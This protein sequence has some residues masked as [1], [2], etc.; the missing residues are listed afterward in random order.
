[1]KKERWQLAVYDTLIFAFCEFLLFLAVHHVGTKRPVGYFP[2]NILISFLLIM[3]CRA[4]F[5]IYRLIW[6]YG[7]VMS[8]A[9]III[10][11]GI[12]FIISS[13]RLVSPTYGSMDLLCSAAVFSLDL[14]LALS[15]RMAYLYAFQHAGPDTKRSRFFYKLL[16]IFSG[17][18]VGQKPENSSAKKANIAILGAG[19]LG[20]GLA[21]SLL[22]SPDNIFVPVCFIDSNEGKAGRNINGLPV[23]YESE[24]TTEKLKQ[25]NVD[26]IVFAIANIDDPLRIKL[27]NR[28]HSA[29]FHIKIYDHHEF[30]SANGK[31]RLRE[32]E[33]E[34]LLFRKP[35]DIVGGKAE[36]YYNGKTVLI[37]GAG[38]SIGSELA[39]QIAKFL[40][41]MLVL[42]DI[43]ENGVYDVE[44]ELKREYGGAVDVHPE[45]LS[46]CNKEGLCRLFEK[47]KP[48][49]II[50]AAAHKHVPLMENNSIEAIENNVFGTKT[51]V[52]V[53]EKYEAER[54]MMV[55]TDKAVNPT[56]VMGAT[57]RMCEMIVQS[58]SGYGKVKYSATRFGNVLG[59][60]G[61]VI[62]LFK[63]QIAAGGPITIT[64]KR[65]I[66]Y[67]MTIPEASQLVLE[68]GAM[69]Q[70]GEL[71]VLD[72]GQPVKIIDLAENIIKLSGVR[73]I[74]IVETGLRP[75]EKLY[76][77]LLMK[78]EKL[79]K[80]ENNKIFIEYDQRM[81]KSAIDEKLAV[82][83]E[84]CDSNSND[85]AKEA[86]K[87]VV[88]TYQSPEKVNAQALNV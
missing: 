33:I 24:S 25:M 84:A 63:R 53:C 42:L 36:K 21:E 18:R 16:R 73:N 62:P 59:S 69:A 67:F 48:Q 57:K 13:I 85:L 52:D 12:A 23:L 58:A 50:H 41:K 74:K 49:I 66:R 71:F 75:G 19:R 68:S 54:F 15:M 78:T 80:T 81:D 70:N 17:G 31:Y 51:L 1:M 39:R 32:F 43:C 46:V 6:R 8:Y 22:N 29:G 3:I 44:Q 9:K 11:D 61:S 20:A 34:D 65:I 86:L 47:Y 2:V 82:L 87:R 88:P 5:G 14:I 10:S 56:N 37:T 45:I 7:G 26:T 77:E 72:M 60:A 35:I 27:Y 64:D 28:Y 55:S 40:P 83:R 76:E 38:G 4:V 79:S 30:D